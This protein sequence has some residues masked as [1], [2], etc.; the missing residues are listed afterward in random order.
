MAEAGCLADDYIEGRGAL[1][2]QKAHKTAREPSKTTSGG[3]R[4]CFTCGKPG[5]ISWDCPQKSSRG[6]QLKREPGTTGAERGECEGPC[7]FRC[8]QNSH[9]ASW[10]PSQPA[11]LRYQ[12]PTDHD[13]PARAY[14]VEE[15]P[16]E[17]ILLDIG[18]ANTMIHNDLVPVGKI[19]K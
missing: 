17:K 4:Q 14:V 2:S 11:L 9:L 6:T 10:C 5:P 15:T 8:H 1:E 12:L 13:G 16:V 19:S 18:A 7:C 3:P